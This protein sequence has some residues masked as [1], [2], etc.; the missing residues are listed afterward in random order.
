VR[1]PKKV[2]SFL[3]QPNNILLQKP[4]LRAPIVI[5]VSRESLIGVEVI[6]GH[7]YVAIFVT[8]FVP[9][10]VAQ[11]GHFPGAVTVTVGVVG[12]CVSL[13]GIERVSIAVFA[14][15]LQ[16]EVTKLQTVSIGQFTG[17]EELVVD[18]WECDMG[19]D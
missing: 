18:A 7:P 4:I 11:P 6:M 16:V 3:S 15:T 14:G 12:H 8:I 1:N 5:V 13:Q 9:Q 2:K 19:R 17:N 10:S